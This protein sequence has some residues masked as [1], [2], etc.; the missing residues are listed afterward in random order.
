MDSTDDFVFVDLKSSSLVVLS[1]E[2]LW[3]NCHFSHPSSYY[4]IQ[5]IGNDVAMGR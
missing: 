4:S 3:E 5:F 1:T 2:I